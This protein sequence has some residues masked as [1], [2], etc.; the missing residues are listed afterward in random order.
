MRQRRHAQAPRKTLR[1]PTD[2]LRVP[3]WQPACDTQTPYIHSPKDTPHICH[4]HVTHTPFAPY[5]PT[6]TSRGPNS[7]GSPRIPR[8][9]PVD[10]PRSPH[11]YP[12]S[13]ELLTDTMGAPSKPHGHP[14]HLPRT[15][16]G[17][18]HT[19]SRYTTRTLHVHPTHT[20]RI[21]RGRPMDALRCSTDA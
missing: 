8:G 13:H 10:A 16:H 9:L 20:P 1:R 18:P 2:A 19:H 17:L 14:T 11:G 7:T 4:G 3:H 12:S 15:P 5:E 21:P 6:D